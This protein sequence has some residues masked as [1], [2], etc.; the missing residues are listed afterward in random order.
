M[1]K[2]KTNKQRFCN[3]CKKP[4]Q[5]IVTCNCGFV[6]CKE[7]IINGKCLDCIIGNTSKFNVKEYF[8]EKKFNLKNEI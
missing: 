2:I 4:Y 1:N 3:S 7:C 5:T 6:G 8:N